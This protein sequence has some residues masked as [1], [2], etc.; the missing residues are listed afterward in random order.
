MR[1]SHQSPHHPSRRFL[2]DLAVAIDR[3]R[4]KL[5]RMRAWFRRA[6]IAGAAWALSAATIILTV[7][8]VLLLLAA[9]AVLFP[10]DLAFRAVKQRMSE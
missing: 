1:M 7:A 9:Y 6:C 2:C 4:C 10:F 5:L 8:W 3:Q